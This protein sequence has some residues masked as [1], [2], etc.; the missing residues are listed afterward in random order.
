MKIDDMSM[1]TVMPLM[2]LRKVSRLLGVCVGAVLPAEPDQ[3]LLQLRHLSCALAIPGGLPGRLAVVGG[4]LCKG[5]RG[6]LLLLLRMLLF[7]LP[8]APVQGC[9]RIVAQSS[10]ARVETGCQ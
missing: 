9:N 7:L 3:R 8:V 6:L 10:E 1:P 4:H 5:L 2:T